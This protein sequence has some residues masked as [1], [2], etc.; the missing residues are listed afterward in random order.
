[1]GHSYRIRHTQPDT[2]TNQGDVKPAVPKT[3]TTATTKAQPY[4]GLGAAVGK[5]S[6]NFPGGKTSK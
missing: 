5:A 3:T 6:T 1:M 2:T 4:K